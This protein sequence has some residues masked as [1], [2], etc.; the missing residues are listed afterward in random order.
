MPLPRYVSPAQPQSQGW[1]RS[2]G[3]VRSGKLGTR[4]EAVAPGDH[5]GLSFSASP[6]LWWRL[7]GPTEHSIQL[8]IVDD[9]SIDPILRVDI[10]GPHP[11]GLNAI[12][13]SQKNLQLEP[14]IDYRWFV[15]LLVDPD[16]PSRNPISEG[17]IRV[18]EDADSRR[19]SV[20][21]AGSPTRG[22]SL[23]EQGIWYDAYDFFSVLAVEHPESEAI[24]RHRDRLIEIARSTLDAAERGEICSSP[25]SSPCS[26]RAVRSTL[27]PASLK[28]SAES[29]PRSRH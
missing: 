10:P 3:A 4:V 6:R 5:T 28:K 14:G 27:A 11:A 29:A 13:L 20:A 16:R 1:S 24:G 17:A 26:S 22:H 9:N 12:D 21:E 7:D 18:V 23:A 25:R 15:A 2:F 8:T 19:N